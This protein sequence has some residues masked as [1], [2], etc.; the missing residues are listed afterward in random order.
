MMEP[1]LGA[2]LFLTVCII[3]IF[4]LGALLIHR[5]MNKPGAHIG[6]RLSRHDNDHGTEA[7]DRK[8]G[9]DPDEE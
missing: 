4:S 9:T 5:V 6:S 2:V 3:V 1:G 8:K 7:A